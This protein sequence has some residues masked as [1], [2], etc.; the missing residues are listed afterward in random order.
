M[1]N[2]IATVRGNA[3]MI[4]SYDGVVNVSGVEDGMNISVYSTSGILSGAST[5]HGGHSSIVTNIRS[6][7]VAIVRIGNNSVKI[8]MQ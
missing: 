8:V 1:T 5:A 4:Q 2:D 6:G 7:E 3:I